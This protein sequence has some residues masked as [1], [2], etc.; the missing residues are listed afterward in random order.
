M[1][2]L[3][4]SF[5]VQRFSTNLLALPQAALLPLP[6][7]TEYSVPL[8]FVPGSLAPTASCSGSISRVIAPLPVPSRAIASASVIKA[9]EENKRVFGLS[10]VVGPMV[11]PSGY[12]AAHIKYQDHRAQMAHD[13]YHH[14]YYPKPTQGS[15][16][17]AGSSN[18]GQ[19]P[20]A[21]IMVPLNI[22]LGYEH[23]RK[24]GQAMLE[25]RCLCRM[26]YI[27]IG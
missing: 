22:F 21:N 25:V 20:L 3:E 24:K 17:G 14:P 26:Q 5:S 27:T 4:P 15:T 6:V 10:P 23:T 16:K 19:T 13:V 7:T 11:L 1:P 12:N 9:S 2:S 8:S 18:S